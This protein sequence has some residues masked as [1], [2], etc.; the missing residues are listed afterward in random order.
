VGFL[1]RLR[2]RARY[3]TRLALSDE[4]SVWFPRSTACDANNDELAFSVDLYAERFAVIWALRRAQVH[5]VSLHCDCRSYC[6]SPA[7]CFCTC[8]LLSCKRLAAPLG[9]RQH[10]RDLISIGG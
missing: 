7:N 2:A 6:E 9:Y 3:L 1:R 4:A 10:L 8:C 5:V